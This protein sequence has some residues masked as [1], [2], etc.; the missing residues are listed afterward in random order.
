MTHEELNLQLLFQLA[1]LKT[2]SWLRDPQNLCSL[3]EALLFADSNE[4]RQFPYIHALLIELRDCCTP[5]ME[6]LLHRCGYI[7]L[8]R[9]DIGPAGVRRNNISIWEI[10]LNGM[11]GT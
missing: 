2:K 10:Y 5:A 8:E 1:D 3:G 7:Q 11:A 6:R 4:I 9:D